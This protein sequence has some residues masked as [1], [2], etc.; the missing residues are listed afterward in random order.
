MAQLIPV[1]RTTVIAGLGGLFYGS[2]DLTLITLGLVMKITPPEKCSFSH[3]V[4]T[5]TTGIATSS[6]SIYVRTIFNPPPCIPK[7]S[8][9]DLE[10]WGAN[11]LARSAR[12]SA[13]H[14]RTFPYFW[15]LSSTGAAGAITA[16][17]V[18]LTR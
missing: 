17:T 16:T 8:G 5:F 2:Y 14:L 7:I 11:F 12:S 9:R 3:K 13:H 6:A 10:A 18:A 4:V 15:Y 1:F